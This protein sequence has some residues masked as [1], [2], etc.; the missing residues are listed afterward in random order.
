MELK[1]NYTSVIYIG[2][3]VL[4]LELFMYIFDEKMDILILIFMTALYLLSGLKVI[5]DVK[6]SEIN[7]PFNFDDII[8]FFKNF[9]KPIGFVGTIMIM[10]Y[11]ILSITYRTASTYMGMIIFGTM[12]VALS[13]ILYGLPSN[14]SESINFELWKVATVP[15]GIVA[16]SLLFIV[17]S[18]THLINKMG[19]DI[20]M[21]LSTKNRNVL[22][23]YK[24]GLIMNIFA[25][26]TLLVYLMNTANITA[27]VP[28]PKVGADKVVGKVDMKTYVGI[29][30]IY[31][32]SSV[33]LYLSTIILQIY[34]NKQT[35]A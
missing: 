35:L 32:S 24:T 5:T 28:K 16:L 18:G 2:F 27:V 20:S 11:T 7:I 22:S 26:I 31:V 34:T 6:S 29:S 25:C 8:S 21:D 14:K 4:Y 9:E 30:F 3:I 15:I 17:I 23:L 1:L 33:L 10:I 12:C 19:D 13:G